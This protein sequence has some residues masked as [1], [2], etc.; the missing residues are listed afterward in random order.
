M[1]TSSYHLFRGPGRVAVS[2]GTPKW[3]DLPVYRPLVPAGWMLQLDRDDYERAYSRQ[4]AALDARQVVAD[5]R[6]LAAGAE[7]VLCC[8]EDLRKPEE[9]CH[10]QM[11]A[12]WL[13]RE[14]GLQVPEYDPP[15]PPPP[16]QQTLFGMAK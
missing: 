9:W 7:P 2:L 12:A 8:W 14:L 5:L 10:R 16:R 3:L 6:A 13:E 1:Q 4:L 15:A 11:I